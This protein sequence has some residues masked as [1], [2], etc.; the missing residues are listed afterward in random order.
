MMTPQLQDYILRHNRPQPDDVLTDLAAETAS[1]FGD[2]AD[3]Q[4][5]PEQGAFLT[6]L[7]RLL[8]PRLAVEVGTFTGY[9][10]VC[11]AR[12][13]PEGGRLICC[14]LSEDYTRVARRYWERAGVADRV[15]LRLAP[16]IDTLRAL[17]SDVPVDLAFLDADKAGYVH[18]W[19]AL[20]ARMPSGGVLLADNV[21]AGGGVI[22]P[23]S[24]NG[25]TASS[26][27]RFNDHAAGDDRVELVMLPI[28][29]GLTIARRI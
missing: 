17:P 1:M 8:A 24:D 9:S 19:D 26:I 20:L 12:G 4:V 25:S 11:I 16:A 15:E 18:Y 2:R 7:T 21:F 29:D 27:R 13:L 23:D 6:L 3:M 22:D 10:S 14:D 5:A 28:A